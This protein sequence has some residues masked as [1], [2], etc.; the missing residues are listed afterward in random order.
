MPVIRALNLG[1]SVPDAGEDLTILDSVSF[2]IEQGETV[3]IT[4][5]SGSG[6]STLLGLLA[7]LDLPSSGRLTMDEDDLFAWDEDRRARWRA[8]N[9]GFV[10]QAFQLLPQ[11]TAIENVM[12]PL[13]LAGHASPQV[14]ARELLARVGLGDRLNHYPRTLSGGEQQRVALARAFAPA[15]SLLFADEPTGSLDHATGARIIDLLFELNAESG[16]TLVLVTHDPSL[17]ARCGRV[18]ALAS[19]ALVADRA[20]EVAESAIAID[21]IRQRRG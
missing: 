14:R 3:A 5:P 15:P 1:K 11:M 10:F 8:E 20:T 18:L 9:L 2:T 17:A 7:G 12:L 6:K 4:G 19:G 16:A 21:E 13:E